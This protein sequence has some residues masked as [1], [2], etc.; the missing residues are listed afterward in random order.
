MHETDNLDLFVIY[1]RSFDMNTGNK[2]PI[3][4]N[5]ERSITQK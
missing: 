5:E 1:R 3:V 2:N 4:D